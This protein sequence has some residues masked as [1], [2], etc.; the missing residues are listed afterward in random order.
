MHSKTVARG[1][2]FSIIATASL[3]A[4]ATPIAFSFNY[5]D[6]AG[7]GFND[8]VYGAAARAALEF[9]GVQWGSY[10]S[11]SYIGETIHVDTFMNPLGAS[12]STT[13]ASASPVNF[14]WNTTGMPL[15][16]TLYAAPLANH[17]V[18]RDLSTSKN[19]IK[20]TFNTD[21]PFY[22]GTDFN[23]SNTQYDFVSLAMHEMGHG[24]GFTSRIDHD[25]SDGSIG[26]FVTTTSSTTGLTNQ[27]P[28]VYDRFLV[29]AP[30]GGT[31]LIDMT[32]AQRADA[33]TSGSL[34]WNGANGIAANG[35]ARPELYAPAVV[36]AGSSITHFDSWTHFLLDPNL[37]K[38]EDVKI[39]GVTLGVLADMGWNITPVPE[40]HTWAM[41]LAGLAGMAM[42]ARRSLKAREGRF[43]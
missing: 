19:E 12:Q 13:L 29:N 33:I 11:A 30:V 16:D 3:A 24:L 20:I 38:G 18:G 36:S 28:S 27:F 40:P 17:V 37:A 43:A 34:Y 22:F 14:S 4:Q 42:R 32:D 10:L 26:A 41:M 1:L 25:N 35:G 31:A 8:P 9:A 15:A 39:D 5:L 21:Q 2:I 23:A 7:E 6:S